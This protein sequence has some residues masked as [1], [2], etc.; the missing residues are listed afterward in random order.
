[1]Y[2]KIHVIDSSES[3]ERE[4]NESAVEPPER[5]MLETPK[6]SSF[7]H[8]SPPLTN[9]RQAILSSAHLTFSSSRLRFRRRRRSRQSPLL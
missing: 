2:Y 8:D 5:R 6:I 1:M 4:K 7:S 3:N 9:E